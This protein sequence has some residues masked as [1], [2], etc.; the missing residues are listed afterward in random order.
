MCSI[1]PDRTLFG[2]EDTKD[3]GAAFGEIIYAKPKVHE[4]TEGSHNADA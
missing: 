3:A 2:S 1:R 4:R